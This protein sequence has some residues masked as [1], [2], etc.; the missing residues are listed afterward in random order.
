MR[1][2][3]SLTALSAMLRS[4]PALGATI[5]PDVSLA[6]F[7]NDAP[8]NAY[9]P[10]A[11]GQT[12]VIKAESIDED[13]VF[14]ERSERTNIGPGPV[15]MGVQTT[16]QLD[17]A[18]E[19]DLLVEETLDYFATDTDGNVWYFGEDVVNYIYDDDG[20]LIGTDTESSWLAEVDGA[21]PGWIMPADPFDGLSYFQEFAK[22]NDAL[23]EAR[24]YATGQTLTLP[25]FEMFS[26][27]IV[28]LETSQLDPDAREFKYYAPGYGL[29]RADEGLSENFTDT[30]LI[31]ELQPVP[32][33]AAATLFL[34]GLSTFAFGAW[35]WKASA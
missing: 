14:T 12:L 21:L 34:T 10:L 4:L 13:G 15:L 31:F 7:T 32:L 6:E 35:R 28:I 19:D 27:V 9:F 5:L 17:R 30:E 25:G 2:T 26:G 22:L 1:L 3:T 18:Y 33:P 24:I 29:I 16:I 11:T 23:D 20:I 8:I